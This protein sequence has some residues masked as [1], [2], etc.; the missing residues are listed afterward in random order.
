MKLAAN[1]DY[2]FTEVPFMKRFKFAKKS[3]F[4]Y[5]EFLFPYE[6]NIK[7]LKYELETNNLKLVQ[8]NLSPGNW[9]LGERGLAIDPNRTIEFKESVKDGINFA[10]K[11]EVNQLNC[12]IGNKP[13]IFREEI[14]WK[15]LI[16][17]LTYAA[18]EFKRYDIKLLIEPINHYDM[19][20][21]YLNKMGQAG[22]IIENVNSSNIYLQYDIYHATRENEDHDIILK[23]YYEK[24]KH[25]QIADSPNRMQPGSGD[26]DF[27]FIFNELERLNYGGYI[28]MEYN[29]FPNTLESLKWLKKFNFK[30]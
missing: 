21:F 14:L 29:P 10:T 9:V 12:L 18:N 27:S 8:F 20:D 25:I 19:P 5:V 22:K 1:L 2:L 17:N 30:L 7:E 26:I 16:D 15:N 3:G 6:Y 23:K 11:L 13:K 4:K 28:S 24:I